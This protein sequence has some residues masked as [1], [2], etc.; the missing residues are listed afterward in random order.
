MRRAVFPVI[1]VV[2]L[3][4]HFFLSPLYSQNTQKPIKIGVVSMITPVDTV[5]YYQEIIDYIAKKIDMPVELVYKKT[6]DEMDRLLEKGAV[7]AAFIC[8]APYVEDRRK[9]GAELLVVPQVDGRVFYNSFIIVH[10]DSDIKGFDDLKGKTFAF[11]D[12][13]SNSGRLYTAYR[14]AKKGTRP[15][16]FFKKYIYSYSHNKSIELVAKKTVDG[17]SVES[18]IYKF[19]SRKRSPYAKQTRIIER[20]HDFGIPPMVTT[21]FVSTFFKEKIK[22]ILV[23]MHR[24]KKG[25]KI[26]SAMLIDKFVEGSDSNYDSVRIMES[27]VSLFNAPENADPAD[28]DLVYFGVLPRDNPRIAYEKYQPLIDYLSENTPYR[29]ELVLKKTYDDTVNAL[30]NGDIDIAFLGPLTY[31][32]AHAQFG[33]VSILKSVTEKGDPHYRGVII[34]RGNQAVNELQD[35]KGKKFAFAAFESTSGNLIPRLLLAEKGIHLQELN[36]YDNFN[37][38]D[39]VVK[40]VLKGKYDA[41]AVRESVAEKYLP[42]GLKVIS[43]SGPIPTGPVVV[44]P[45]TPYA[46]VEQVKKNLLNL[47]KTES[48]KEILKKADPELRGGFIEATDFDYKHIRKIINQ[49]P[50]TCGAGCHPKIK[51]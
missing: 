18:L 22:E 2:L 29:F 27:F 16:D 23:N 30:G 42:L 38:H 39:S 13:K 36:D 28:D 33:A 47:N 19:M 9:F 12:P 24:D 10:K 46:V 6:Y 4:I 49:I 37:S 1:L 11:T 21:P 44:G 32:N 25:K 15:E 40:W 50:T 34:A 51:L 5:K 7:D 14:L 48:G 45:K 8:S 35:L 41:G 17:A 20:S 3:S 31:L 43:K 26:L